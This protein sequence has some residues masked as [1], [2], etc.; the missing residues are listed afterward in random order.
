M[1]SSPQIFHS[2]LTHG[3]SDRLRDYNGTYLK[4]VRS[5]SGLPAR[6]K[7]L[8]DR[9]QMHPLGFKRFQGVDGN[10]VRKMNMEEPAITNAVSVAKMLHPSAIPVKLYA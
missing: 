4:T 1:A 6:L 3:W 8:Y 7:N 5:G 2:A 10:V 9:R